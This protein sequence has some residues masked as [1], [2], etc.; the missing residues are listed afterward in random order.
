MLED[1]LHTPLLAHRLRRAENPNHFGRQR[2]STGQVFAS[3]LDPVWHTSGPRSGLSTAHPLCCLTARS[4]VRD[5][6][7]VRYDIHSITC[8]CEEV[9]N[10]RRPYVVGHSFRGP[11]SPPHPGEQI[12][13]PVHG[14][15]CKCRLLGISRGR[16]RSQT[17]TKS[18]WRVWR[19]CT[20]GSPAPLAASHAKRGVGPT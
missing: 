10:A 19:A 20:V 16:A 1:N 12:S 14:T 8:L 4:E 2:R 15:Q 17:V 3:R 13:P 18:R 5:S 6:G 9:S 11:S 7:I